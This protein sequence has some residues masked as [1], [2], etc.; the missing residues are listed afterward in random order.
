M[1]KPLH[2]PDAAALI[3]VC[4]ATWPPA[5][6]QHL[7]AWTIRDGQGGGSR[8]SAAT[9]EWPVTDA[10]L[11][12]AETAMRALGQER[13]FQVRGGEQKLDALLEE[14]GYVMRDPVNIWAIDV[15]RLTGEP[16]PRATAY[17]MW[18]PLELVREIWA[19]GGVGE[20]RQA[21]MERATCEKTAILAR[22]GDYPGGAAYVGL[23]QGV[24]M[25][26]A[27]YVLP[28]QRRQG[29]GQLLIRAAAKWA[30]GHG[31]QV[32]SLIVTQGNH[33]AN[34]LYTAMGMTLVGHYHYRVR[35]E[36]G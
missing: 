32:L 2:L 33:A 19:D 17:T 20:A 11:P 1:T 9:E 16:I 23:H 25:V 5:T 13:L 27:L 15:A 28:A 26:H 22:V 12:A 18:P 3:E 36:E 4:E 29:A 24:A 14:H 6:R 34:P 35:P 7:G 8:V 31:A 10:D 30:Q 21:V